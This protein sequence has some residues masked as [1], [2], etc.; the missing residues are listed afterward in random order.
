MQRI[1]TLVLYFIILASNCFAQDMPERIVSLGPHL[2]EQIYLL[3]AQDKLV[4]VTSYC[5]KPKDAQS[6]E[7]VGSV[8]EANIEKILFLNPDVVLM[9]PLTDLKAKR[10]LESLGIKV[11]EFPQVAD[12]PQICAQTL[13][14]GKLVGKEEQAQAIVSAAKA[15]VVKIQ[16]E[17]SGKPH[18]VF[19]QVGANPLFTMNKDFFI[20]DLVER[21]GGINIGENASGGIFSREKVVEENPDLIIIT[22]MGIIGKDEKQEWEKF[23]I[24]NAVKN[25]KIFIMDSDLVCSPTPDNFVRA[26]KEIVLFMHGE[27]V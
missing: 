19:I 20:H 15:Q 9:I 12:F 14:L 1:L 10:R 5:T 4:G 13:A 7:I 27:Q 21:A 6:K 2:T 11:V 25:N 24:I 26:L 18:K 17:V 3:G 23:K 16:K 8:V 22:T